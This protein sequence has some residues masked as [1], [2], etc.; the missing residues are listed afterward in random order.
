[1][2]RPDL[3]KWLQQTR[4]SGT[5][6]TQGALWIGGMTGGFLLPPPVGV[7][8]ADEKIWLRLGQFVVAIVLGLVFFMAQRWSQPRHALKW[9]GTGIL[10]LFLAVASF[11]LYQQLT[12]SWTEIY[13]GDKIVV[14]SDLTSHGK[15]LVEEN[16]KMSVKDLIEDVAGETENL[17]T[18][19][20]INNRRLILAATYVSC[21]PLFT[22]CLIATVQATQCRAPATKRKRA[23]PVSAV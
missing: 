9:F 13:Y 15:I 10:F 17:W 5:A 6:M 23:R 19:Q 16:P 8:T 2:P 3:K 20:S 7:S 18:R 12:V 1:M 4:K 22:I 21:L 14:G 11:F